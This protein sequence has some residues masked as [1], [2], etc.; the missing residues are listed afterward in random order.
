[1]YEYPVFYVRVPVLHTEYLEK[2]RVLEAKIFGTFLAHLW[3]HTG[4]VSLKFVASVEH[5]GSHFGR[6]YRSTT[7]KMKLYIR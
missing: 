3:L 2:R 5:M 4:K 1:M 6:F 7:P